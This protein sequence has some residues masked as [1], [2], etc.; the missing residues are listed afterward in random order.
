MKSVHF[1]LARR[2]W[3]PGVSLQCSLTSLLVFA[4]LQS[5]VGRGQSGRTDRVESESWYS[6]ISPSL[7]SLF[8]PSQATIFIVRPL[9]PPPRGFS[10]IKSSEVLSLACCISTERFLW[11]E[12][13]WS[14]REENREVRECKYFP[15]QHWDLWEGMIFRTGPRD[16]PPVTRRNSPCQMS[17][18]EG[19]IL[20]SILFS[21]LR[22]FILKW[23]KPGIKIY[24][25]EN[26]SNNPP[27]SQT[28]QF[29]SLLCGYFD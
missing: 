9:K 3:G 4:W 20:K 7:F 21:I 18:T 6:N 2:T 22:V 28:F 13:L 8:T 24:Y 23:L 17:Q 11:Q 5:S 29:S 27:S 16:T 1:L 10:G 14:E 26:C 12:E 25:C 19:K 15:R